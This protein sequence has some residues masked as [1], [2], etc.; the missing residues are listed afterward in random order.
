MSPRRRRLLPLLPCLFL[1]RPG[2]LFA[3]AAAPVV[4]QVGGRPVT[5]DQISGKAPRARGRSAM[6]LIVEP[7]LKAYLAPFRSEWTPSE[8]DVE[9]FLA[10]ERQRQQC[11]AIEPMAVPPEHQREFAR[12]MSAQMKMQR[13]IHQRHGGGRILFQQ[14]GTEAYDATRRLLL[15]LER[16]GA[17]AITDPELREQALGYWLH[18][19]QSGLMPDPGPSAFTPE[20]MLNP[21]PTR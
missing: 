18:D 16:Q 20:Q 21:C 3:Q 12:L 10:V 17:F 2:A 5:A 13:F 9:H 19:P 14:A 11:G 7:A 15:N 1:A 4:G 8:A 6:A